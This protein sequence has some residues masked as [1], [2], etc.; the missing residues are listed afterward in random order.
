MIRIRK[1]TLDDS[2]GIARVQVDS[3]STAYAGILPQ[4][5]LG[6]FTCEEQEQDWRDWPDAH[7][8]DLLYVAE[9]EDGEIAGYALGRP[10]PGNLAGYD[11]E[12]VALHV[13]R[14]YRRQ[15]V[16][17]RLIAAMTQQF[18]QLGC[19]ALMLWVLEKNA[20]RAFYE[21]LGGQPCGEQWI[22][23]GEEDGPAF[24]EIAYGWP[25]IDDLRFFE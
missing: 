4:E 3:Y 7:P 24:M 2:A 20:A 18:K 17:R 16:G 25:D 19:S 14:R 22:R 1:A 5:Y 15:G 11:C 9:N 6:Q 21:R 13:H 12:L 23:L 8:D 10:G